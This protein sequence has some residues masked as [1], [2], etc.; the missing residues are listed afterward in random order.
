[1]PRVLCIAFYLFRYAILRGG[2]FIQEC[3][4]ARSCLKPSLG[5][6]EKRDPIGLNCGPASDGTDDQGS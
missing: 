5:H 1:M 6:P 3:D 2:C 4:L